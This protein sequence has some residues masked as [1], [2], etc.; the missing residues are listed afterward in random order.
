MPK[1]TRYKLNNVPPMAC[2]YCLHW[3]EA[4]SHGF[5]EQDEDADAEFLEKQVR[6][7][8]AGTRKCLVTNK[9]VLGWQSSCPNFVLYHIFWCERHYQQNAVPAC[10]AR[11]KNQHEDCKRC[12][13]GGLLWKYIQSTQLDE[14]EIA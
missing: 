9:E 2:K 6:R 12:R 8:T 11:Q 1:I 10:I 7:K 14:K 13:Q 4:L 3:L 5:Q